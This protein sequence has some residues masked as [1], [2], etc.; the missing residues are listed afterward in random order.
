MPTNYLNRVILI[1][2]VLWVSLSAI[3]QRVPGSLYWFFNPTQPVSFQHSLRP[4]ID[5]AGGTS[6]TYE[7]KNEGNADPKLAEN[8]ASVLKRRVDPN[9]VKNLIWRP[10]GANR[11]EIQMPAS[12]RN[13]EAEKLQQ[14]YLKARDELAASELKSVTVRSEL[15]RLSG[16]ALQ[17]KITEFAA[18]S[19]KRADLL[20]QMADLAGQIKAARQAQNTEAAARSRLA[21][22]KL[23][24]EL[25]A[26]NVPA[27]TVEDALQQPPVQQADSLKKLREKLADA[28]PRLAALNT[29]V[30]AYADFA[31]LR[32]KLDDVASLKRRLTGSGV[33]SFHILA[34][35]ETPGVREMVDRLKTEGPRP[36][37]GDTTRW[38]V[39]DNPQEFRGLAHEYNGK[40]YVLAWNDTEHAL[41]NAPGLPVWGLKGAS[42]EFRD[43][44]RAVDFEFDPAGSNLF[45][46]LTG[47]FQKTPQKTYLLGIVLDEKLYSAP[48]IN[49]QIFGRGEITGDYSQKEAEDLAAP[50]SA[51]ALPAQLTDQPISETFVGPQLGHDNLRAG[52]ISCVAGLVVVAVF[53]IGYYYLSG[54]VAFIAVLI[55]LVIICGC[56]AFINATFT[57]PGI[58]GV[59]L[60]VA[61]AVDANVLIFERLREEQARGLSLKMALRN[62]YDRAFSA[63]VDGQVTTAISSVFLFWFGSEEVRGFG[64]TLL[65]GIVTSLFTA[66]YV[67]KTI[68][69]IM[70][71][72]FGIKDLSSL[73]RTYPKWNQLLTPRVDWIAKSWM[74]ITFSA[75]FI[76]LGMTM[77]AIKLSQGDALDIEFSGGTTVQVSLK[78]QH[79]GS[80]DRGKLQQMVD[81]ISASRPKDLAAPRVVAV[82]KDGLQYQ[83]SSPTTDTQAVQKA[84]VEGLG[85]KLDALQPSKF[86][87][88]DADIASAENEVVFPIENAVTSVADVPAS[89]LA[90]H[91]GGVVV[92]LDQ[93]NPPLSADQV[94]QRITDRLLQED[95]KTRPESIDVEALQDGRI[96]VLMSDSRFAYDPAKPNAITQWRANLAAPAWSIV[97][98]AISNPPT[99]KGVT[100]F[101]SQV[102]DEAKT[103]TLVALAFSVLGIMAYIWL[104]FGN[105]KFGLATV[106]AC[107]HDAL[108]VLAAVGM[109]YYVGQ[110]GFFENVLLIKPFRLD[111]TLVAAILTV[112]GYSMNDTVVVFDRVRENRGRYGA[113]SRKTINDSINQTFSRTLLTG[114]TSIVILLVMYV[115]GG[116][117][118][119][120]F[121]FA[122]LLGII[123]GTYSSIAIASP[124]LLLGDTTAEPAPSRSVRPQAAAG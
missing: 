112:V 78:E 90:T 16:D 82:G 120:A 17:A 45:G 80:I 73:P 111:L 116:E 93:I 37:P 104:R 25:M 3:Y 97:R 105:L 15:E 68:F 13:E 49:T 12:R 2:L 99:L 57:L 6:L 41:M 110:I 107:V 44:K 119:H 66:L 113:L 35:D 91:V 64:L 27:S 108:F 5:I 71:D 22:E 75:V 101:N 124:L 58:A 1:V 67:T 30:K 56:M 89:E 8:V 100:S 10:S 20:K 95:R 60:S 50:L 18:G 98:E 24:A 63:I 81:A 21:Y 74:F 76:G 39:V 55:N 106:I 28:P 103:N 19:T 86:R 87:L 96:A 11:L 118:I 14:A 43:G 70:V 94:R 92:V 88:V 123:V 51:G 33:L 26:T 114:G 54:V 115:I 122:M 77:F 7:I 29:F 34:D 69:A 32:D 85:D 83:I 36:Q 9:G 84:V 38:F 46:R 47:K 62:S 121:T 109:S 23:E 48:A 42:A 72:R 53:M 117:G 59:V 31:P 65:I 40:W 102:A 79:R 61:M 4:G 52:L